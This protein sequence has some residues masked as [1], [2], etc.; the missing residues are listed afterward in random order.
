MSAPNA[1]EVR[2]EIRALLDRVAAL[3][4]PPLAALDVATNRAGMVERAAEFWGEIEVGAQTEEHRVQASGHELA[5][6]SYRPVPERPSPGLVYFHG[7]GWVMGSI[8]TH[9]GLC[10][11]LANLAGCIVFSVEYRLAPEHA[12][13]AA[14]E[15]AVAAAAWVYANAAALGV[16]PASISVAGDSAGGNLAAVAARHLT[17]LGMRLAS[18][19]LIYPVASGST[20][21]PSYAACADGYF[22]TRE[23]MRWFLR[24]Y[25]TSAAALSHP[26]LAPLLAGD[27]SG[28]PA[29]YIATCEFDPLRDDGA[30]Y[31]GRLRTAGVAV[32]HEDWP[33]M[34]HGFLLM[35]TIT[36]AADELIRRTAAFLRES[37]GLRP[38][39]A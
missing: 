5:I 20:E 8:E 39:A 18:Q 28:L 2:A 3:N 16:D 37:W 12:F 36:P 9:D 26:D 1:A 7:G 17:R 32:T 27:L 35:R 30:L 19:V 4:E 24:L 21:T 13:P 22:L 10:R 31:A 25:A 34:I 15:D 38:V 29:A 23:D 14:A 11:R 33:G 6:R